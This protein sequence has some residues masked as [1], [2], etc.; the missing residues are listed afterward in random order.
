MYFAL[1]K[2]SLFNDGAAVNLSCSSL[3][4]TSVS[5]RGR[6][7]ARPSCVYTVDTGGNIASIVDNNGE[8]VSFHFFS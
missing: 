5:L 8:F 7:I 2:R 6:A 3:H 4:S 1:P